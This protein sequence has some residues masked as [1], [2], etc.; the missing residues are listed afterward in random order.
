MATYPFPT[1][2]LVKIRRV[3]IHG[4]PLGDLRESQVSLDLVIQGPATAAGNMF[5]FTPNFVKNY[6]VLVLQNTKQGISNFYMQLPA[7][8]LANTVVQNISQDQ[9]FQHKTLSIDL[10]QIKQYEEEQLRI[11]KLQSAPLY[12]P[13]LV[14][15]IN[16]VNSFEIPAD[17]GKTVLTAEQGP[18]LQHL[19]Y[20][21]LPYLSKD[22]TVDGEDRVY[23]TPSVEV[24]INENR[25]V[26]D[27]HIY[28]THEGK[29]YSDAVFYAPPR[30]VGSGKPPHS[31]HEKEAIADVRERG[32]T[33]QEAMLMSGYDTWEAI[34]LVDDFRENI[35]Y[36]GSTQNADISRTPPLR[37]LRVP[38]TVVHDL[39]V[40]DQLG[41]SESDFL[42]D[43]SIESQPDTG[44]K[45]Y[46]SDIFLSRANDAEQSVRYTF[47]IDFKKIVEEASS[48]KWLLKNTN[49]AAAID[50]STRI[51]SVKVFRKKV[52]GKTNVNELGM[53]SFKD[54]GDDEEK[55]TIV[56]MMLDSNGALLG[57]AIIETPFSDSEEVS[58]TEIIAGS[59]S[60]IKLSLTNNGIRTFTGA[61]MK[62]NTLG[63]KHQYY[64]TV[65]VEDATTKYIIDREQRLSIALNKMH[66]Y[67]NLAAGYDSKTQQSYY[68]SVACKFNKS[69]ATKFSDSSIKEA[70]RTFVAIMS[71]LTTRT[72][73]VE[74]YVPKLWSLINPNNGTLENIE[75]VVKLIQDFKSVLSRLTMVH[76]KSTLAGNEAPSK[77]KANDDIGILKITNS[78]D[79]VYDSD[80]SRNDGYIFMPSTNSANFSLSKIET[81]TFESYMLK[82]HNNLFKT[83]SDSLVLFDVQ[84][85]PADPFSVDLLGGMLSHVTPF[86]VKINDRTVLFEGEST[87]EERYNPIKYN[88]VF[89]DIIS[90]GLGFDASGLA[91]DTVATLEIDAALVQLR[92]KL[93]T[94]FGASGRGLSVENFRNPNFNFGEDCDTA[95]GFKRRWEVKDSHLDDKVP[96]PKDTDEEERLELQKRIRDSVKESPQN[97]LFVLLKILLS[98]SNASWFGKSIFET[99]FNL[100][101]NTKSVFKSY[102]L[103]LGRWAGDTVNEFKSLP[104]YTKALIS[105]VTSPDHAEG[106][107]NY[108][109]SK[110]IGQPSTH[111]AWY[112][113]NFM[114]IAEIQ[115]LTGFSSGLETEIRSP[116][117]ARMTPEM[118]S[119]FS[120]GQYVLCRLKRY[121]NIDSGIS[122]TEELKLSIYDEYFLLQTPGPIQPLPSSATAAA[123]TTAIT[124]N[125]AAVPN[126]PAYDP[127]N[128]FTS[129]YWQSTKV[130]EK[131]Q[132]SF[133]NHWKGKWG[134]SV[135][136]ASAVNGDEK[137]LESMKKAMGIAPDKAKAQPKKA[138]SSFMKGLKPSKG[139]WGGSKKN[140]PGGA[141]A[142]YHVAMAVRAEKA[143]KKAMQAGSGGTG[144]GAGGTGGTSGGGSG[145]GSGGSY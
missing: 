94:I 89:A 91:S 62:I 28:T 130:H 132:H 26:K 83:T 29:V 111:M 92:D 44:A 143:R 118:F 120:Q 49:N 128:T 72:V 99:D 25:I 59:M 96:A 124:T 75:A 135:S 129:L 7:K 53:P 102:N 30:A 144:A 15:K 20:L 116:M 61:D 5:V 37:T 4:S 137:K 119:S 68:N 48:N 65:E 64:A 60:E 51:H 145:G 45:A 2:P 71:D 57:Q 131:I 110:L 121:D 40:L 33:N 80:F 90:E 141:L 77:F 58:S 9:H 18:S 63:G 97:A 142:N 81:S 95:V 108:D 134:K 17:A 139:G 123:A 88:Q 14:F 133:K 117:F 50:N 109:L 3:S 70:L 125:T 122:N 107:V 1:L 85:D 78:F 93:V 43:S 11:S 127:I 105:L 86:A 35:P 32:L 79:H 23:G 114:N 100:N 138:T 21:F 42:I 19:S 84:G 73:T 38:N 136:A 113:E 55:P 8:E 46:F 56:G 67:S 22:T 27:A 6:R 87:G 47:S 39:R 52:N 66:E 36:P 101:A 115:V 10:N 24:V 106:Q 126:I 54:V 41:I 140:Q 112:Y 82:R 31:S 13:E 16:G 74:E 76:A 12:R 69:F 103:G 104:N 34:S 98:S